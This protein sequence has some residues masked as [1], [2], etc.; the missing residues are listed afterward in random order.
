MCEWLSEQREL[1]CLQV[2]CSFWGNVSAVERLHRK[3]A[4]R[5]DCRYKSMS[6]SFCWGHFLW[7]NFLLVWFWMNVWCDELPMALKGDMNVVWKDKVFKVCSH[8]F[9]LVYP[10][11][12]NPD[13]KELVTLHKY[14][15]LHWYNIEQLT[16]AQGLLSHLPYSA[17][18][19]HKC[20]KIKYL[21]WIFCEVPHRCF[22]LQVGFWPS[23]K[24][25]TSHSCQL[26]FN[27]L[28]F[29]ICSK[30]TQTV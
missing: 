7:L 3:N 10:M 9:K 28:D 13:L 17:T 21:I 20:Y 1:L 12:T 27:F 24:E 22:K 14:W 6:E 29:G 4:T 19:C 25:H 5:R 26:L 30:Y 23:F 8:T 11:D 16:F 2:E 18:I 15:L